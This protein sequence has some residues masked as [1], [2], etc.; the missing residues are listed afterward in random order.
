MSG[1][2]ALTLSPM[3][4]SKT[5]ATQTKVGRYEHW[6]EDVSHKVRDGYMRVLNGL[7]SVRWLVWVLIPIVLMCC[8]IFFTMSMKELAPQE[9][10]GF[11]FYTGS[12][13]AATNIN[14]TT[15][16]AEMFKKDLDDNKDIDKYFS[17]LGF[18]I[19]QGTLDQSSIMGGIILKPWGERKESTANIAKLL[20]SQINNVPGIKAFVVHHHLYQPQR[21]FSPL[22]LLLNQL[23]NILSFMKLPIRLELLL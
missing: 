23:A 6:L 5:F 18:N 11:L 9:D 22:I 13:P 20:T 17:I 10:Q 8:Y 15:K 1:F 4:C 7:Y 2:I 16:Y 3:M 14:Y 19:I 21:V 12:G